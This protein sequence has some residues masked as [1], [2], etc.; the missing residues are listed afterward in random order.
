MFFDSLVN[1]TLIL[2]FQHELAAKRIEEER[3]GVSQQ[4]GT[5]VYVSGKVKYLGVKVDLALC[6]SFSIY[7]G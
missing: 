5:H 2:F 6:D 7:V 1:F 4:F 3:H